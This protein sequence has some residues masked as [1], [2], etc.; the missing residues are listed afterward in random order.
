MFLVVKEGVCMTGMPAFGVTNSDRMIWQMIT[1]VRHLPHITPE[2][3]KSLS[4]A[5]EKLEH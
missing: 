3:A 2:E 4:A 5:A 1:F